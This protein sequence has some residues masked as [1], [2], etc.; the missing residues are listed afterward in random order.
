MSAGIALLVSSVIAS[1]AFGALV[2][3]CCLQIRRTTAE[4]SLLTSAE[5]MRHEREQRAAWINPHARPL[6]DA[7]RQPVR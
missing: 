1:A 4:M 2:T 7:P 5:R 6:P 3:Y